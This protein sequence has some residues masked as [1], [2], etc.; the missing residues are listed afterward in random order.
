MKYRAYI[1]GAM[2]TLAVTSCVD[3]DEGL[4]VIGLTVE[5]QFPET[6]DGSY[7]GIRV[8]L[9]DAT[10][11]VFVDSTDSKGEAHFKVPSG[12]YQVSS[13]AQKTTYD[14]QYFFNGSQTQIVVSSDSSHVVPLPLVMSKKRIVH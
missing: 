13:S 3:Y 4:E 6:Y 9:Q 5:L 7:D 8:E 2:M 12:L 14:Y 10:A 11:S 1:L